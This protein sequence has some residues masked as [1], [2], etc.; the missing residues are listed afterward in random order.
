[1]TSNSPGQQSQ[2]PNPQ[3][4]VPLS[5]HALFPAVVAVWCA[6]LLGFGS[7][8]LR[9]ALLEQAVLAL[10][11]DLVIPA[12]APPLGFTA[13][14]MLALTFAA[15]GALAGYLSARWLRDRAT[16]AGTSEPAPVIIVAPKP[17]EVDDNEDLARL[18]AAREAQPARRRPLVY[19]EPESPAISVSTRPG[20]AASGR[21]AP[22]Y[23]TLDELTEIPPLGPDLGPAPQTISAEAPLATR[24]AHPGPASPLESLSV[25]ELIARFAHALNLRRPRE[26]APANA[27]SSPAAQVALPLPAAPF[28]AR[29][30]AEPARAGLR[31]FDMPAAVRA[32][33]LNPAEWPPTSHT[34]A[35][36]PALGDGP[37]PFGSLLNIKPTERPP[38][39]SAV[40]PA[41]NPAT[42]DET[43]AALRQALTKLQQMSNTG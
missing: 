41:P 40:P 8:A 14:M 37:A 19:D 20:F 2:G 24:P 27:E 17:E 36:A 26:T 35:S 11:V 7:L 15:L 10:Q 43:E 25:N 31:P 4:P 28:A 34:P 16:R 22:A 3:G 6:I 21:T 42:P 5:R 32:S 12:A 39:P 18:D 30:P 23:L 9:P 33:E 13:R 38:V 1:M 29:H